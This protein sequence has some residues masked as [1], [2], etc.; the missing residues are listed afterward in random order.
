MGICTSR[1]RP[2]SLEGQAIVNSSCRSSFRRATGQVENTL[3]DLGAYLPLY[4]AAVEGKWRDARIYLD[5]DPEALTARIS[6]ASE[7]ALH[8]A[9]G[10]GERGLDFV[11][12]L[13]QEMSP[14]DLA[15]TDQHGET[16]FSIAA[17]VGNIPAAEILYN[18]NPDLP[19]I[20]GKYGF[21]IHKAAQFSQK[22]MVIY[23]KGVTKPDIQPNPFSGEIGGHLL[24]DVIAADFY[25]IALE[26][27][28]LYPEI[29]T[30][31]VN[32]LGSPLSVLARKSNAFRSGRVA[33]PLRLAH[34]NPVKYVEGVWERNLKEQQALELVKELCKEII[35]LDDSKVF[36]L[37]QKA[38]HD[39]AKLGIPEIIEEIVGTFPPAIWFTDKDNYNIFQLAM[40]NRRENVFNLIYQMTDYRFLITRFIDPDDNNMLHLVG[41]LPSSDRL[42]L[43]SGP[44]LLVQQE[45]QW[46]K[47]VS[48]F[49]HPAQRVAKNKQ[50]KTPKMVFREEHQQLMKDGA[51][52]MKHTASSSAV[53]ATLIAT[54][55]FAGGMHVPGGTDT[56]GLPYLLHQQAFTM[57]AVADAV[58]LL[59]SVISILTFLSIITS[60]YSEDDFHY[61][62]PR[63]L[64]IGIGVLFLS[65]IVMLMAFCVALYLVFRPANTKNQVSIVL[66]AIMI[67]ILVMSVFILIQIVRPINGSKVFGKKKDQ[68]LH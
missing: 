1:S 58:S 39:A 7:T 15:L 60:R 36:S 50:G 3:R 41:R 33:E 55:A 42:S 56:A 66:Y 49:I 51:K 6:I 47:Q 25:D 57:F 13:V 65:I 48:K 52:W 20:S 2:K 53:F 11:E 19:N 40:L 22:E 32:G 29:A 18:K 68:I 31:E 44:A 62:L 26:L 28:K 30:V 45:M 37:L 12:K 9:V 64:M 4:K 63:R 5:Q 61:I 10:T 59:L 27:V 24:I 46:F 34:F 23:L 38:L 21:P 54:V 43:V 14:E 8:I 16:A 35:E 67:V 17:V